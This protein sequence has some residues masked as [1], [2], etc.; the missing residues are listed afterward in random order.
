[1][2][3]RFNGADG[4]LPTNTAVLYQNLQE[5]SAFYNKIKT[6]ST[7]FDSNS[8]WDFGGYFTKRT[9]PILSVIAL[10][11]VA[12]IWGRSS[13]VGRRAVWWHSTH[14]MYSSG[15]GVKICTCTVVSVAPHWVHLTPARNW[16]FGR[17]DWYLMMFFNKNGGK[18]YPHL[19]ICAMADCRDLTTSQTHYGAVTPPCQHPAP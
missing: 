11:V 18:F 8:W 14:S 7:N 9:T 3:F 13:A 10:S 17:S 5:F 15:S 1:M 4:H 6:K 19:C 16:R 2:S 12:W